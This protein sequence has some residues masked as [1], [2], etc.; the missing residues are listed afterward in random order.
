MGEL[1]SVFVG[2]L[3]KNDCVIKW[4]DDDIMVLML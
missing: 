4:F 3:E 1:G 2:I